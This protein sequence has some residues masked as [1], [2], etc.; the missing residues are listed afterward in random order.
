MRLLHTKTGR[1]HE[2][3]DPRT[4]RYAIL[5]HVWAREGEAHYPEISADHSSVIDFFP[6]E[7][8]KRLCKIAAEHNYDYAW[9]DLCCTDQTSS[10]ELSEAINS[11]YDWYRYAGVCYVFLYDVPTPATSSKL[12]APESP[13]RKSRWHK[14]GWTL[15]E[16]LAPTVVVFLSCDWRIIGTKHSLAHLIHAITGIDTC[17]LT[18]ERALEDFSV[19]CRMSWASSRETKRV[20]DKAYSLMGIFGVNMPTT[21]GEGRYAFIRLQEEILKHHSDQTIF[22]WGPMET[23]SQ[24]Q[25]LLASS[26]KDFRYSSNLISIP[27]DEFMRLL[28]APL[29]DRPTY[30]MTSYGVRTRLPLLAVRAKNPQTNVPTCIALLA[31]KDAEGNLT[32]LLLR[33]QPKRPEK[34]YFVGAVVGQL[35]D[36]MGSFDNIEP[37]SM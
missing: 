29:E 23:S 7:K 15:Q 27:W 25:F 35:R 3:D 17:I 18:G 24:H 16:L 21:Y 33:S 8:I 12:E 9:A 32:T 26:P 4:V 2:F 5:S 34:D 14:R 36:I 28:G 19:A 20:E 11:M 13:F 1:F 22:A 6:S 10:S 30:T 31:C 37:Y